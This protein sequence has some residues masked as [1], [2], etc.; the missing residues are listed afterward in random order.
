[1]NQLQVPANQNLTKSSALIPAAARLPSNEELEGLGNYAKTGAPAW[2][3]ELLK[4]NGKDGKWWAGSQNLPIEHG[5]LL[6]A[7]VPEMLAGHVL[8]KDGELA[9]Q[10]WM[11][12]AKFNPREHRA[13]LGDLDQELWPKNEKGQPVDPWREGVMLP[14]IDPATG[15]EFTFSSSSVGGVRAGK[16]LAN[17]YIKQSR[18]A[19]ETTRGCLPL[20]ALCSSSYDRKRGTIHNPVFEGIDWVRASDLLLPCEPGSNSEPPPDDIA[21][22]P[23]IPLKIAMLQTALALIRH[24][25]AVFPCRP[26]TKWPACPHGCKDATLD[27]E[28]VKEWWTAN[29]NANIGVATGEI[30]KVFVVDADGTDGQ[31]ELR[32]LEC[33]HGELPPTLQVVTANGMHHY[34]RWPGILVRNSASKIAPKIDVRGSGGYCLVPPSVHPSGRRYTWSVDSG[35]TIAAAPAWLIGLVADSGGNIAN[36]A[37]HWCNVIA[38][39]VDEGRMFL[40]SMVARIFRPGCKVDHMLILEG[41]QGV[42]KSTVCAILGG[43]WF[44]DA[45]P[46]I[47]VGK[48]VSQH[49][50]GKWL[51]EVSELHAM[52][53]A[54]ATLLK[55]FVT[56]DTERYRPSYGRLEVIEPRQ[57]VFIGTTNRETYLRDETGGRRFWPVKTGEIDANALA[58]D[59]DQLFAEAVTLFRAGKPWW[60]GR[61]FEQE[62]IAAEQ[63]SR[64][65]GD[66]WEETIRDYL[67]N[68][69]RVTVGQVARDALSIETPRISTTDQRRIATVLEL[70]GWRRLPRDSKGTRWWG[71]R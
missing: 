8:W 33:K 56:R 3:G 7:I 63:A 48:D 54:E 26:R 23:Q 29:P 27:P 71:K 58:L 61:T 41:P 18:A 17:T 64:Y 50:R 34:F 55:S 49:L 53:R 4:F 68:Q 70:L 25:L 20:V 36:P 22:E 1:M 51:I 14:M 13:T 59:R 62:H 57:C 69:S 9:D 11:P 37:E 45:L 10:A 40:I 31:E 12:A 43:R 32:K 67:A 15:A 28:V 52:N 39:G 65:E 30:S 60:P 42:L 2:F 5:R 46:D 66:A 21:S 44:S 35:D 38:N 47:G 19:P 24:G 6:V 16:R